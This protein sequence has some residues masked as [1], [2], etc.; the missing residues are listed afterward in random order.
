MQYTYN[1]NLSITIV[2]RTHTIHQPC[3]P[4]S[5]RK[6]QRVSP[7]CSRQPPAAS[8]HG[9]LAPLAWRP[10]WSLHVAASMPRYTAPMRESVRGTLLFGVRRTSARLVPRLGWRGG[11]CTLTLSPPSPPTSMGPA[12]MGP[13]RAGA[14]TAAS[15]GVGAEEWERRSGSVGATR[16]RRGRPVLSLST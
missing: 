5:A 14:S 7:L 1:E 10:L 11:G 9:G 13:G 8:L 2:H 12:S 3:R 6:P 4:R 16:R 15:R